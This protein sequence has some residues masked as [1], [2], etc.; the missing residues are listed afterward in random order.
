MDLQCGLRLRGARLAYQ[1][2][3]ELNASRDNV[4]V[5]PTFFSS[6][7]EANEPMIGAGMA[8]DPARYFIIVPNLFG[9]GISSSAQQHAGTL[10]PRPVPDYHLLRQHPVPAPPGYGAV[11]H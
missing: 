9:N 3:G 4:I 6:R 2:Y 1:T 11:R 5:F 8:L 10:R 7:H